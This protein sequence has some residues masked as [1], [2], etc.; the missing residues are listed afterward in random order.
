MFLFENAL[1]CCC[2]CC[3]HF[4]PERKARPSA[5]QLTEPCELRHLEYLLLL[6]FSRC[7][8]ELCALQKKLGFLHSCCDQLQPCMAEK[9][10]KCRLWGWSKH[11]LYSS[12]FSS[13]RISIQRWR[14]SFGWRFCLLP[15]Q[16]K[17][18]EPMGG[19]STTQPAQRGSSGESGVRSADYTQKRMRKV[20]LWPSGTA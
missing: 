13:V 18:P 4:I 8:R 16:Q 7:Q 5:E 11:F 2:C 15:A 10:S 20:P 6:E 1:C 19:V 17:P 3:L 9:G 14:S 12:C